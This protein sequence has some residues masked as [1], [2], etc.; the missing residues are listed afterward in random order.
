MR[1]TAQP[2]GDHLETD[3]TPF[4][5]FLQFVWLPFFF[6]PPSKLSRNEAP[7]VHTAVL[8]SFPRGRGKKNRQANKQT[9][10]SWAL[11]QGLDMQRQ[12]QSM[13]GDRATSV[14][15]GQGVCV[16]GGGGARG[17]GNA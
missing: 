3:V 17:S 15:S 9:V 16:C 11:L 1:E 2:V 13:L 7:C 10:S 5:L 8:L 12:P 4:H 14:Q 6:F